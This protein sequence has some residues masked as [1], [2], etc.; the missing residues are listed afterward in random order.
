MQ[1]ISEGQPCD[2][3]GI[4]G[5]Q[6][7]EDSGGIQWPLRRGQERERRRERRLFEDGQYYHRDGKAKFIFEAP[8]KAAELPD[9][10]YPFFLLTGRGT[11]SQWHTQTRTGKSDVL[12]KLY[13]SEI[14]VEIHPGD[15]D[16]LGVR[17]GDWVE[18]SSRRGSLRAKANVTPVVQA[19]QVFIPMH[20]ATTNQLTYPSV[21]PYS[22]QPSYKAAAVRILRS[23]VA[24]GKNK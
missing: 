7:L 18:V 1:K 6:D 4:R 17:P 19:G 12:K 3:T 23:P 11:S 2:I 10:D 24:K 21:D 16:R 20:Y 13:P 5:Y 22:R 8:R 14:Y 9:G 15:A